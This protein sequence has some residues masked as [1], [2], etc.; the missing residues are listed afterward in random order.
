[1]EWAGE[2]APTPAQTAALQQVCTRYNAATHNLRLDAEA[3]ARWHYPSNC[4][5][6]EYQFSIVKSALY[7]NTLVVLPTGLGKT[8]IAAVVML[9]FYRWFPKGKVT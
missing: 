5:R 6:R 7:H 1:M 8:L 4:D 9:N 2:T 3:A